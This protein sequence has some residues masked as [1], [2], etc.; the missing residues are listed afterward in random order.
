MD[1][2]STPRGGEHHVATHELPT[3]SQWCSHVPSACSQEEERKHTRHSPSSLWEEMAVD[4][5]SLGRLFRDSQSTS[6][7][8][9]AG[10][11]FPRADLRVE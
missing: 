1:V 9:G 3:Q 11:V 2:S 10:F 8:A 7:L 5:L 6:S 4:I